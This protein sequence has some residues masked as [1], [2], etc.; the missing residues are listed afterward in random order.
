MPAPLASHGDNIMGETVPP[1]PP[2]ANAGTPTELTDV[3]QAAYDLTRYAA[4]PFVLPP[5]LYATTDWLEGLGRQIEILQPR[6]REALVVQAQIAHPDACIIERMARAMAI[7]AEGDDRF[8]RSHTDAARAAHDAAGAALAHAPCPALW[9]RSDILNIAHP[10]VPGR[11]IVGFDVPAAQAR[12]W[13]SVCCVL[14][15]LIGATP[16]AE[17]AKDEP[18]GGGACVSPRTNQQP[19]ENDID[20]ALTGVSEIESLEFE[21]QRMAEPA[22]RAIARK[23]LCS[24]SVV[25]QP[26]MSDESL[27]ELEALYQQVH[28]AHAVGNS[29]HMQT[30]LALLADGLSGLLSRETS[31]SAPRGIVG[32]PEHTALRVSDL[33][34]GTPFADHPEAT[35]CVD[36]E[37]SVDI[38]YDPARHSAG[39]ARA[40]PATR[41]PIRHVLKTDREV[42]GAVLRGDRTAEVRLD[43]RDFRVRDE[44]QLLETVTIA[45]RC[46][47]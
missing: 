41:A 5:P 10:A 2:P 3:L 26:A 40:K 14:E 20:A 6:L 39:G 34:E 18:T 30:T 36:R 37:D 15:R 12:P 28:V 29:Q 1:S 46:G 33:L 43:D 22:F 35:W 32:M 21:V 42:F 24:P 31:R 47:P 11:R 23:L 38:D 27:A 4:A 45:P 17:G 13:H 8:W 25:P 16:A 19:H 7:Q 9:G 44:L